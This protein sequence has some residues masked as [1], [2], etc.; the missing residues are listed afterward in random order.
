MNAYRKIQLSA[1]AV[2][3]NSVL[4]LGLV[5]SSPALA[6]SCAPKQFCFGGA[7]GGV[8]PTQAQIQQ[9]CAFEAPPGCTVASWTCVIGPPGCVG[10]NVGAHV[11]CYY[12]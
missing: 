7:G 10:S 8:C 6:S 4:A 1:A 11:T 3:A 2:I 9:L 5:S 12:H